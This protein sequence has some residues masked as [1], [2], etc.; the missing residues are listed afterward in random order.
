MPR[1]IVSFAALPTNCVA[2]PVAD[3]ASFPHLRVGDIAVVDTTEREPIEHG[4]FVIEYEGGRGRQQIVE[5]WTKPS[6]WW[7][8][9]CRSQPHAHLTIVDAADGPYSGEDGEAYLSSKLRGRV[10]GVLEP[11]FAEP[12]RLAA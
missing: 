6:G 7:N 5:L 9:A 10:I 8:G 2:V 1:A 4:L 3:N 11:T 12:K